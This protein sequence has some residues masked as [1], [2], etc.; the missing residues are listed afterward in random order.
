[1]IRFYQLFF[2]NR[3]NGHSK[4]SI[5]T[6]A[7]VSGTINSVYA[8]GNMIGPIMGGAITENLNF[9]WML[10][11][12][13]FIEIVMLVAMATYLLVMK[14]SQQPLSADSIKV[15]KEKEKSTQRSKLISDKLE[16]CF[17]D[18]IKEGITSLTV[19]NKRSHK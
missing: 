17:N 8:L 19:L 9:P 13:A 18:V 15:D 16:G 14:I 7:A 5:Q 10:T 1:M 3:V 2:P 11:V 4:D 12:M 6:Y